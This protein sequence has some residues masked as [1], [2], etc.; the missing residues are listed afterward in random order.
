[1]RRLLRFVRNAASAEIN[2][3]ESPVGSKDG[4]LFLSRALTAMRRLHDFL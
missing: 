4:P 1:M 3:R 2:E